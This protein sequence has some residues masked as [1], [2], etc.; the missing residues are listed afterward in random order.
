MQK[1]AERLGDAETAQFR[2]QRQEMIILNPEYGI[3]LL[4]SQQRAGHEG[5][6]FAIAEIV[7]LGSLDQV[8]AGMQ[9]RP[10]R[11]IGET[12]VIATVMRC[13]QIQHRQRTGAQCFNFGE[14]F[15]L[16][17]IADAATGTHPN[18][19]GLFHHGK[20]SRSEAPG[21]G[22]VDFAPRDTI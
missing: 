5:V 8:G 19:A 12:F 7:F 15:L 1:E 20:Q 14:R 18:R 9:R 10:Q 21:H 22:L 17:T 16:G 13:R 6:H 3:R 2:A 4:K 11:R